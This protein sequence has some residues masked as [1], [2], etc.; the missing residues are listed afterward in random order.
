MR[1]LDPPIRV[2]LAYDPSQVPDGFDESD[3]DLAYFDIGQSKWVSLNATVE[4]AT[5]TVS[6]SVAHFT[7]FAVV[8]KGPPE[9]NWWLMAGILALEMG[10]ALGAYLYIV[11]DGWSWATVA[12]E[13]GGAAAPPR[14][15]SDTPAADVVGALAS[16]AAAR[17]D[18]P[19][20]YRRSGVHQVGS[21]RR[22]DRPGGLTTNK[23]HESSDGACVR[24]SDK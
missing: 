7:T 22:I 20:R 5:S 1:H 11:R 16:P 10:L 19:E 8:T 6:T 18:T 13:T 3:L 23:R 4:P 24:E 12:N 15:R 2:S 21:A 17:P 14:S 9:V